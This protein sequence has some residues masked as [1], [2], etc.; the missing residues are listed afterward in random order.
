MRAKGDSGICQFEDETFKL[1]QV[2]GFNRKKLLLL[3][4]KI[5]QEKAKLR[6]LRE[7]ATKNADFEEF[8]RLTEIHRLKILQVAFIQKR[9]AIANA[10]ELA[11]KSEKAKRTK[12]FHEYFF[13]ICRKKLSIDEFKE[14]VQKAKNLVDK[15][16]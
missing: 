11:G 13:L 4:E 7:Q 16:K 1:K 15:Q 5:Y 12:S 8:A 6:I 14:Y 9:V 3:M 10:V 2:L